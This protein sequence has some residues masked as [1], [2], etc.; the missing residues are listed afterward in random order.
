MFRGEER[1]S[2]GWM[3]FETPSSPWSLCTHLSRSSHGGA[4]TAEATGRAER[5]PRPSA[6]KH[7]SPRTGQMSPNTSPPLHPHPHGSL[8]CLFLFSVPAV[9][10]GAPGADRRSRC[11]ASWER[12]RLLHLSLRKGFPSIPIHTV[13]HAGGRWF[14]V[15]KW[16]RGIWPRL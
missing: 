16:Q 12:R 2:L 7:L 14:T 9:F 6:H 15:M 11:T 1:I 13:I 4:A 5:S 3:S 8:S 10:D